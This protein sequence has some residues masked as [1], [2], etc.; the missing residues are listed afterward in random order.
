[1]EMW[2]AFFGGFVGAMLLEFIKN[3]IPRLRAMYHNKMFRRLD[4]EFP[5]WRY[6]VK[7]ASFE[8]WLDENPGM[9]DKVNSLRYGDAAECLRA[10][11]AKP[12]TKYAT[13]PPHTF[14]RGDGWNK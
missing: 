8:K 3:S 5:T 7:F 1:M 10:Y 12:A 13:S 6:D 2:A 9:R 4:S 11:Y 14:T